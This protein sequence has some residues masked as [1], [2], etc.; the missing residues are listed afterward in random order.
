MSLKK[1]PSEN[2]KHGCVIR[3]EEHKNSATMTDG[4]RTFH[5]HAWTERIISSIMTF[6]HCAKRASNTKEDSVICM[7]DYQLWRRVENRREVVE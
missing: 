5:W 2:T 1:D 7:E 4:G 3:V 6:R